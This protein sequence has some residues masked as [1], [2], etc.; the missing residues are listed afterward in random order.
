[1]VFS[2][3]RM[4]VGVGEGVPDNATDD[5]LLTGRHLCCDRLV[6][7]STTATVVALPIFDPWLRNHEMV[8]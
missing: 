8:R 4:G 2:S 6:G 7:T 3:A 5:K 1:M